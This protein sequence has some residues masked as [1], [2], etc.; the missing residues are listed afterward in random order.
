MEF[1][2]ATS[3]A[4]LLEFGEDVKKKLCFLS[5]VVP[6]GTVKRSLAAS[7]RHFFGKKNGGERVNF[8]PLIAQ[9]KNRHFT[10]NLYKLWHFI[11]HHIQ[12]PEFDKTGKKWG[13]PHF[14]VKKVEKSIVCRSANLQTGNQTIIP[15][16]LKAVKYSTEQQIFNTYGEEFRM[17]LYIK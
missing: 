6:D 11:A 7:F 17:F 10:L 8:Q 14:I 15:T 9:L 16:D 2:G 13:M 1:I 5:E 3:Q 4:R 12:N